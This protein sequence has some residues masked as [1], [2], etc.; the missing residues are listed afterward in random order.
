MDFPLGG[1]MQ[2]ILTALFA[3]TF[4]TGCA[5]GGPSM[6]FGFQPASGSLRYVVTAEDRNIVETPMG[7]QETSSTS[8][9]TLVLETGQRTDAGVAMTATFEDLEGSSSERGGFSGGELLGQPY[10]GTIL[11]DGVIEI[12]DGPETPTALKEFV[13]PRGFLREFLVP[14]PPDD[15]TESWA[16]RR[17]TTWD[18]AIEMTSVTTGTARMAGD[19]TWNGV[20]ARIIVFDATI[21]LSGSG[22]PAGS[23]SELEFAAEGP[24][25]MRFVWDARRGVMLAGT[26]EAEMS[27]E[28]TVVGMGMTVPI[29]FEG[30][31]SIELQR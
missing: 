6:T 16:V 28:V 23:P 1:K 8:R 9:M 13:D 17:E 15:Q 2:R 22:M 4:A 25:T 24:A 10:S 18:Q 19:T 27:G 7:T 31:G 30:T 29:V 3:A 11:P 14:L 12:T 20:P 21:S 26:S 5:S